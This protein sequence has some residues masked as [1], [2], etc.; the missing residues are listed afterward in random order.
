MTQANQAGPTFSYPKRPAMQDHLLDD[1]EAS[2]SW[3]AT[4]TLAEELMTHASDASG[5]ANRHDVQEPLSQI[6]DVGG[7]LYVGSR[8]YGCSIAPA[9]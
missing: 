6:D 8:S 9:T 1:D 4:M 2:M 3:T 5:E 7:V